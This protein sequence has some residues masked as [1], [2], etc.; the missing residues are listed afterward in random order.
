MIAAL[1]PWEERKSDDLQLN[2]ILGQANMRLFA[3]KEA[4]VFGFGLPPILG[5]GT[6]GG[7]E[8]MLEDRAGGDMPQLA[9]AAQ[10]LLDA[11]A[12][13]PALGTIASTF[14]VSVPG[15]QVDLDL[16]KAQTMG[17]PS[18]DVYDS[19]QTFLGG[20]YVNDFN[21]FGRTWRVI[22]QA[23]P[24]Y[25]NRPDSVNEFY[26]RTANGDMVPLGTLMR[27]HPTTS[28]DVVYRYNRYRTSKLMGQIAPGS[29]S[30]QA[31]AAM[32][33]LAKEHL[34]Q[35]FSFEWTGTVFQQKL[36]EGKE[37]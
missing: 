19:L 15:Y 28:P 9:E 34:P 26:M 10:V 37:V 18:A 31:V 14:R 35:G 4:F 25:R 17:I 8:F 2:A 3:I 5:L 1:S 7:F 12:K 13:D 20:L 11:A 29:T 6:S 36:S 21:R 30:G 27:I 33:R 22:M 16:E 23:E 24:Q 32:E